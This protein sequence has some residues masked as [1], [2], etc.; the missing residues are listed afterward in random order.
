MINCFTTS[1]FFFFLQQFSRCSQI[2]HTKPEEKLSVRHLFF[3]GLIRGMKAGKTG[4]LG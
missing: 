2:T 4:G 1:F 3:P